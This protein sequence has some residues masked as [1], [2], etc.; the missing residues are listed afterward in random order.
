MLT[1]VR[2]A[3][4]RC[5]ATPPSMDDP[6]RRL[7]EAPTPLGFVVRTSA[8]YWQLI[9]QKHPNMDG[10]LAD[11]ARCLAAANQMRQSRHDP[12]VYL[13]YAPAT[14][15]HLCVVV[16]RLG[17]VGFVITCYVTDTI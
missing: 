9:L 3:M 1:P 6:A 7:I 13:F 12:A 15:Y 4:A 11:V 14:P 17:D 5:T 8:G 10:R 2:V 16:K